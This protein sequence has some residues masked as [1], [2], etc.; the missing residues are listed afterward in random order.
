MFKSKGFVRDKAPPYLSRE[1]I[2]KDIDYCD[3]EKKQS[4][5]GAIGV[6][7]KICLMVMGGTLHNWHMKEYILE[8]SILEGPTSATQ[9]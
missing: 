1:E 7:L 4:G 5:K 2:E 6:F 9:S 8:T 3:A